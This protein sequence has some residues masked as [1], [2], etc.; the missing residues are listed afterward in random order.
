MKAPGFFK[1][2]CFKGSQS[3]NLYFDLYLKDKYPVGSLVVD[4]VDLELNQWHYLKIEKRS[5]G[6]SDNKCSFTFHLNF[7]KIFEKVTY[8]GSY[9]TTETELYASCADFLRSLYASC[10]SVS[11]RVDSMRFVWL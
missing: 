8:C 3:G 7:N 2:L 5:T 11:G 1:I 9:S 10:R 4:K 6:H